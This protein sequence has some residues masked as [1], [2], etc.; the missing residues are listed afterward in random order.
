MKGAGY[1][2]IAAGFLAG[3]LVCVQ[4]EENYV[5][6]SL[7]GPALG[8]GA[9]GVALARWGNRRQARQEGTLG[10]NIET[11]LASIERIV[12]N[13]TRLNDEKHQMHPYD[14]HGRIDEL[15][16]EDVNI[17]VEAR[18]SIG[19]IYGLGAYADVMN[20][21][22]AGE[23]Y[24]NRVWS[25]SVDCYIDDVNEYLD[26]AKHQFQEARRKLLALEE[27]RP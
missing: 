4:T 19:H 17:F 10:G 25:A 3:S 11:L 6:W 21:F 8:L 18:E 1:L 16:L 22:A 15:F 20:E 24:L 12:Q 9:V 27:S 14:I 13:I 2:M 26:R 7:F 23:R 5:D